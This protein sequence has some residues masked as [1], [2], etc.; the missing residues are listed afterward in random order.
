MLGAIRQELLSGVAD[1][2]HHEALR[3][4]LGAFPDLDLEAADDEQAAATA[5]ERGVCTART[6]IF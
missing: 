1:P 4:T 5:A 6:R 2:R 3:A